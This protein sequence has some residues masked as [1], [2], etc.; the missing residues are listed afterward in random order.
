[1]NNIDTV[2]HQLV[3]QPSRSTLFVLGM[4][5]SGTSALTGAL[6]LF[7][8]WVGEESELT[9]A[10]IENPKGFWE[11]RDMR[12][13]CD[14]LL[15]SAGT[16]WW[17][18]AQFNPQ[19]IPAD[20]LKGQRQSFKRIIS[21][22]DAHD[23]WVIKEPRLC[24][25]LPVLSDCL[26][27]PVCVLIYRNPLEVARSLQTRNGFSIASGLALWEAYNIHAINVANH[28][29]V[30]T[31]CYESL[32][33]R[34]VEVLYS[35]VDE[36]EN[37]G[38]T[39]PIRPTRSA[40][41]E[42]IDPALYRNKATE[43][44]TEEYLSR[45]QLE[46]WLH[47]RSGI[48]LE[49]ADCFSISEVNKQHLN[50]LDAIETV[51]N[52]YKSERRTF[53]S[54]RRSFE[55]ERLKNNIQIG[56]LKNETKRLHTVLAIRASAIMSR[57]WTIEN[58]KRSFSWKVTAPARSIARSSQWFWLSFRRR[59]ETYSK[60]PT[61]SKRLFTGTPRK[62]QGLAETTS[63]MSVKDAHSLDQLSSLFHERRQAGRKNSGR[64]V[65]TNS[66]M[67]RGPRTKVTVVAW[68][69][70]HN[71]LGRAYL[72]ADVLRRDY[73]VELI[74]ANFPR[75]GG[76]IWAPL[77]HSSRVTIKSFPGAN[78]PEH[79]KH[80][81]DVAKQI[82]GDVIYVSK[83]R[84]PSM[85]LAILGKMHRNRPVILDVDDY[86]LG[87]FKRRK[88]LTLEKVKRYRHKLDFDCPHD[89]IWTRYSESLIHLFKH[90]TVSNEELRKKFGGFVL[91]HIRDENE[92]DPSLY[93]RKEIRKALGFT[94]EDKVVLFA[95]TPR[96]HKGLLRVVD[97]MKKLNGRNQHKL[98]IV[99]SAA[100]NESRQFLNSLDH[101]FV[102]MIPNVS[103]E[104]LPGF[105]CV[106]DLICLLQREGE[107]T[108][109]FQMPAKFTDGL[110]MGI[111]MLV[112]KVPPLAQLANRGLVELVE[113]EPLDRRIGELLANI[114]IYKHKAAENRKV[115]LKE[116][117]YGA[118][119]LKLQSVISS[120]LENPGSISREFH[121]LVAFHREVFTSEAYLPRATL[122]VV[123]NRRP[124][125]TR[126]PAPD[127]AHPE[128]V[129][130]GTTHHFADTGMD[131]VIFWKQNDTGIYGRRQDMLVK[132]LAKDPRVSRIFQFDAP[133]NFLRL[134]RSALQSLFRDGS[135]HDR[136]V[137]YNTLARKL[138]QQRHGNVFFDVFAFVKKGRRAS[139]ILKWIIPVRGDYLA[140]LDR[141]IR[142]H[143]IGKRTTI[144]WVYPN[145]L[146]FPAIVDRF[147]PDLVV[148]DVVDDQ[149]KWPSSL[150]YRKILHQNYGEILSRSHLAFANC[151][152]VIASMSQF[153]D[154]IHL[155][156]NAAEL[157]GEDSRKWPKPKMLMNMKGPVIGYVGNLDTLRL[158]VDLLKSV[159][160]KRSNWNIL[161]IGSMHRNKSLLKLGSFRNVHFLGVLPYER[162]L[163]YMR[164]FDVAIIP[165]L[166]NKLTKH[167]N[168]LKLY[169]YLSLYVPVVTTQI[170]NTDD[171]SEV[172]EVGRS[173]D[174]FIQRIE[175]CL[176]SDATSE[177][178]EATIK[179]LNENSWG[180]RV[181][182][183]LTLIE[184]EFAKQ[185]SKSLPQNSADSW[186]SLAAAQQTEECNYFDWCTVCGHDGLF[187][188]H[189]GSIRESFCCEI[190]EASLRYREQ[191]RLV[192]EFFSE[193]D[194][195]SLAEIVREESFR[196][197]KIFE[198]GLIGPFRMFLRDLPGYKNSYFWPDVNRGEYRND[199]QCQDLMNLT[200]ED[201]EFDLVLS[202]DIFEHVRKPFLGFR[203]VNR[204]L[205]SGGVHVFSVP[206]VNPMPSKTVFRVDT[207]GN[208]DLP[209]LPKRY[210]SAP[211]Q[212]RSL[213]YTDFG[214]DMI[215]K[216]A[217]DGIDLKLW[218]PCS[219]SVPEFIASEMLSF[220]WKKD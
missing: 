78:F 96:M 131:I 199:V 154:N 109:C 94:P 57:D 198:P 55:S 35:L 168:P 162:A 208:D 184:E 186:H 76:E 29:P 189:K 69:L 2:R 156:P 101:D 214:R 105:L 80:M 147:K 64:S 77:R 5:R 178:K 15:H 133:I 161:F 191:A 140:Y 16:A 126:T 197:L 193:S 103:F 128:A 38:I 79:F 53:E 9:E 4:H 143:S 11:R 71:P 26:E 215:E 113:E 129:R 174:E 118:N 56:N 155:I 25:L 50:D 61:R 213:V 10:N 13:V 107:L 111:P 123:S 72:L 183:I 114:D 41:K 122:D 218:S 180:Y 8:A 88:P 209:L 83:A 142:R 124:S 204:V 112:T 24:L 68:D 144:F 90:L 134:A 150:E 75:F 58:F 73:D 34:P 27:N 65:T 181:S 172:V 200:Y 201:E 115:F 202:S 39:C 146:D 82:Q 95:G 1:M 18:I 12:Q 23:T 158:D 117:S 211:F 175:Y 164:H 206:L 40:I 21:A 52:R 97:A 152:N 100:D 104:D 148:S 62:F 20:I 43:Q 46:I 217:A 6:K 219:T 86:E 169:V 54:E 116:F 136:Y 167:M 59:F 36:L 67:I 192:L 37:L 210:H 153:T 132:Y 70:G 195:R 203:E 205:K 196:C 84:L 44:E 177:K 19:A 42:F 185:K 31:V 130:P 141:V 187:T 166:N 108:S 139:Q 45:S 138:S 216:M 33:L 207:S 220:S 102:K 98:L 92:F 119:R 190:C 99:G 163:R 151:R 17:N 49:K 47:L 89:E 160:E 3:R 30:T 32:M 212:G 179:L 81:T 137:L 60:K 14:S 159:A 74:G 149:R 7:G 22:L 51:I 63:I 171:F 194:S 110:S 93:P 121:E 28:V 87:F 182:R 66:I 85:E 188:Q 127:R 91:P 120:A 48:V 165:H 135:T 170:E 173:T 145:N 106:G 176:Q 125:S 157:H